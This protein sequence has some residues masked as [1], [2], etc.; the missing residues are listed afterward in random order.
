M[1]IDQIIAF[2]VGIGPIAALGI[3]LRVFHHPGLHRIQ[4]DIAAAG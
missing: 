2:R 3:I 4:L 1:I